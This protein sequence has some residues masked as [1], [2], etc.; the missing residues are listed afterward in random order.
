MTTKT[1]PA[2]QAVL[3]TPNDSTVYTPA[4]RAIYFNIA[5]TVYVDASE[6][7]TNVKLIGVAGLLLPLEVKK[8]YATGLSGAEV[9]GLR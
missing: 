8:V 3:I 4:F 7:G 2:T 6:L 1:K 9:V 5:G